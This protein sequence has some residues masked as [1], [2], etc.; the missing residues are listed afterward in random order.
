[1]QLKDAS[2]TPTL[3]GLDARAFALLFPSLFHISLTTILFDVFVIVFFIA[4][5]VKRLEM[6]FAYR[7]FLGRFRG[8][9]V[10]ARPWWFAKKWRNK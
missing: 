5:R 9:F 10:S 4:L 3:L 2:R 8:G 7:L 6:G 1:M